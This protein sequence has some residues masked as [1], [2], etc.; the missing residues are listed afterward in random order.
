M[1]MTVGRKPIGT[2]AMTAA[3]RQRRRRERLRGASVTEAVTEPEL[4]NLLEE[5]TVEG[6]ARKI[7]E[8]I[9]ILSSV[10]ITGG[11]YWTVFDAR[12]IWHEE[13]VIDAHAKLRELL[14]YI[15]RE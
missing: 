14:R 1:E 15:N 3:E 6:R 12:S 7:N 2:Q 8:A 10:K 11:E 9:A 5:G 13:D 4:P